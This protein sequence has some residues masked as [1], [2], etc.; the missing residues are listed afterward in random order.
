MSFVLEEVIDKLPSISP[1]VNK[2]LKTLN[3][4][5]T[6]PKVLESLL[7]ACPVI[8]GRVLQISNSSF[9]G[10]SRQINS[11]REA[12]IILGQHTLRGL[13]YSLA[14]LDNFKKPS[15]PEIFSYKDIWSHSLYSASLVR[16][17]AKEEKLD[18]STL[19]TATLFQHVGLIV[20]ETTQKK[21]MKTAFD[22]SMQ[23]NTSLNDCIAD[24]S[25]INYLSISYGVLNHWG[26]PV[27]VCNIINQLENEVSN[28]ENSII[29]LANTVTSAL[30]KTPLTL[31]AAIIDE[32][33]LEKILPN[34]EITNEYLSKADKLYQQ[35]TKDFLD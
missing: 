27:N 24:L 26:F 12:T 23:N 6:E 31:G 11:L 4:D 29:E 14:I 33:H 15:E 9:Y 16:V 18:F 13:I 2:L 17:I 34:Q 30:Y 22:A 7:I 21:L 32:G 10:L 1:N 3:E 5:F 35:L 28:T 19:F 25:G 20:F 8:A